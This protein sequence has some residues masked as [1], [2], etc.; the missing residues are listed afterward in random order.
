MQKC[1]IEIT[2]LIVEDNR[3]IKGTIETPKNVKESTARIL[4]ATK[5]VEKMFY[6]KNIA[7]QKITEL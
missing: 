5:K 1:K 4:E 7:I 2:F 3:E 6:P